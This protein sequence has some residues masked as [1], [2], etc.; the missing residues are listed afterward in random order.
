MMHCA[1][2]SD[3]VR[4]RDRG[5]GRDPVLQGG[6]IAPTTAE[7]TAGTTVIEGTTAVAVRGGIAIDRRDRGS[8]GRRML[9]LG[10]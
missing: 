1:N 8:G 6:G 7:M 3:R 10:R 2:V 4:A 9:L 5:V